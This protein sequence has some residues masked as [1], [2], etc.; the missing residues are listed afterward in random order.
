MDYISISRSTV[1]VDDSDLLPT[2]DK[3]IL[4]LIPVTGINKILH[5]YVAVDS[6]Q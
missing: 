6:G 1:S 5:S 3:S 2:L 4:I